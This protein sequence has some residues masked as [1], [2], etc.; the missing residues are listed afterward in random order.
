MTL[1]IAQLIADETLVALTC[2]QALAPVEWSDARVH[3]PTYPVARQKKARQ[4]GHRTR[5]ELNEL[6]DGALVC[7]L[8]TVQSQANR[9]EASFRGPL[10][11]LIPRHAVEAG[12][13]RVDLTELPHRLA[14]ASVR[15][16]ALAGDI[17]V[18]FERFAAGD[19]A[20]LARLGPTSLVYGAW[21]SR[22]TRVSVPRFIGSRIEARDVVECTRSAQYSAVFGQGEL[23]LTD[24]EWR[25]GAEAGFAPAPANG[26]PGGI[27]VRGGLDQS[28]SILL[29][30]PRR[31]R[32]KDG[33]E[34][35]P[36]YLLGLALGGLLAGGRR[37]DLRSGCAL[38]PAGAP[39]WQTVS[40][41][42]ERRPV[43]VD[44]KAILD[45]LRVLADKWAKA[46]EVTLGGEPMVH[47]YDPERA[48]RML[49][50]R[51]PKAA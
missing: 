2:R 15:A 19:A 22:D 34:V 38:V 37:Y 46:A 47:R 20:P 23:G 10:A 16:T 39:A 36:G 1:S 9:M 21:D 45:E 5:Y 12:G 18:C 32:T 42:G 48:K 30:V 40:V 11:D 8:D 27:V 4:D 26:R 6:G 17:R 43:E 44:A 13:H 33:S 35:L 49:N 41:E 31:Y 7:E 28:A 25:K 51:S 50:A 24:A 3:P 14:D 29:A